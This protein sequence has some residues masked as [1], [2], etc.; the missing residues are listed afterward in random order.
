MMW[1]QER[2]VSPKFS[3]IYSSRSLGWVFNSSGETLDIISLFFTKVNVE[4]KLKFCGT[5]ICKMALSTLFPG[6]IISSWREKIRVVSTIYNDSTLLPV[7]VSY[8]WN[9]W[10][11]RQYQAWHDQGCLWVDSQTA[12]ELVLLVRI[13]A[14]LEHQP[15]AW[16]I[17]EKY[18]K[19][20][21]GLSLKLRD[22]DIIDQN[23][24][25]YLLCRPSSMQ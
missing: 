21:L 4:F 5:Q 23:C 7:T 24:I 13:K 22:S 6:G 19:R 25:I 12:T 17:G 9:I 16:Q 20:L 8:N 10:S 1:K 2:K 14:G 15:L 11:T 3:Y 18:L